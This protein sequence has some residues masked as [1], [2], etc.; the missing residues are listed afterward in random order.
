MPGDCYVKHLDNRGQKY[1]IGLEV[2]VS[3]STCGKC[4]MLWLCTNSSKLFILLKNKDYYFKNNVYSFETVLVITYQIY[5]FL[6]KNFYQDGTMG[7]SVWK[8][9]AQ[10]EQAILICMFYLALYRTPSQFYI[11]ITESGVTVLCSALFA[12]NQSLFGW[13]HISYPC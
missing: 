2:V 1:K 11:I 4:L 12:I 5:V 8:D 9:N 7:G 6:K 10:A 3:G 13:K